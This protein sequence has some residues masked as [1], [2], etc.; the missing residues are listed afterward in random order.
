MILSSIIRVLPQTVIF[1]YLISE[2]F[3]DHFLFSFV[4]S[5]RFLRRSRS[6]RHLLF[7][8]KV[9]LQTHLTE[10]PVQL[11]LHV[12]CSCVAFMSV[13]SYRVHVSVVLRF[14]PWRQ[15]CLV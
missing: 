5:G 2:A 12:K 3:V 9:K 1:E 14:K 4:C 10:F 7:P 11:L 13:Q 8:R 15:L 6:V